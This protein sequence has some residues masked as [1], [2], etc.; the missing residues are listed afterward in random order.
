MS[1][2]APAIAVVLAHEGGWVHNANDA[3]R[4]TNFG[5]SMSIIEREGLQPA[6]LGLPNFNPGAMKLLTKERAA[7]LYRSLFWD[8]YGYG[9]LQNQRVATKVFDFA[10]NASPHQAALEA[11]RAAVKCGQVVTVDGELGPAS[12]AAINA[13]GQVPMLLALRDRLTAYYELILTTHPQWAEF[14]SNWL[15]RAAWGT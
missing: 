14:R 6:D 4:E 12:F 15:L 10:V 9:A 3:G 11:Q 13:C 8:K 2:F 1:D 7:A 5:I